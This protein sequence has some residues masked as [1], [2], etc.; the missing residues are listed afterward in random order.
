[1]LSA[2]LLGRY[3]S[4]PNFLIILAKRGESILPLPARSGRSRIYPKAVSR[5]RE[6]IQLQ[7][8][9][10]AANLGFAKKLCAGIRQLFLATVKVKRNPMTHKEFRNKSFMIF[11]LIGPLIPAAML[12]FFA[13]PPLL[14]FAYIVGAPVAGP[15]WLL[16]YLMYLAFVPIAAKISGFHTFYYYGG[17]ILI[18]ILTGALSGYLPITIYRCWSL[19]YAQQEGF[20]CLAR[21]PESLLL[22]FA[23]PGALCGFV[24]STWATLSGPPID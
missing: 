5:I 18:S 11:L 23:L 3:E 22:T 2:G 14:F 19:G 13:F 24:S 9:V 15:A 21:A 12:G 1:M 16:Y 17:G 8:D 6:G 4:I 20:A 10:S 7:V